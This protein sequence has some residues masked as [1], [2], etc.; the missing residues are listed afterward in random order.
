MKPEQTTKSRAPAWVDQVRAEARP[1]PGI[2]RFHG[3]RDEVLYVG[4]SVRVRSRLLAWIRG[5]DPK[6]TELLRV[7][8]SVSWRYLP[9]EFDALLEEF[10]EI[11]RFRPRFNVVHRRDRRFAWVRIT[12]EAAPRL[13]AT[14]R[15]AGGS[16]R[17][18]GRGRG[19]LYGPFPARRSLP[20][21]LRE[22]AREVG[23]RD[24]AAGTPIRFAGQ[25]DLFGEGAPPPGLPCPRLPLGS[26]P[27]PCVSACSEAAYRA[28]VEEAAAFL[29]GGADV[30]LGRLTARMAEAAAAREYEVAARLR[31]RRERLARLR[32]L[33][34]EARRHREALSFVYRPGGGSRLHLVRRGEVL[35]SAE[36]SSMEDRTSALALADRIQAAW[37]APPREPAVL[38]DDAREALFLVLRWFREHPPEPGEVEGVEAFV[39]RLGAGTT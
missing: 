23:L 17:R 31:D 25:G 12:D 28:R 13:V 22:L 5:D 4:K 26:C 10:R 9:S 8:R 36:A 39:H 38:E 16:T 29:D 33:V 15:P 19:G 14:L 1:D 30:V 6:A 3:P 2:Y 34:V 27:G 32:A 24:C 37:N 20:R 35:L 21:T 11:R 7:T 18:G